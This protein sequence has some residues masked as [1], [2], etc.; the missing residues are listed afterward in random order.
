M[1]FIDVWSEPGRRTTF[2]IYL[3]RTLVSVSEKQPSHDPDENLKGT[4]TVLLVED[5]ESV[6]HLSKRILEQLGYVVLAAHRPLEALELARNHSGHID[7]LLTDVIMAGM[8][9]K[10]FTEKLGT[11]KA[12]FRS[13]FMSGYTDDVIAQHGV[14]DKGVHF[15]QK[16]FS[17]QNLAAKIREVLDAR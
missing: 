13:I 14:L 2:H 4:E 12:G 3:P 5:E 9:G 8:N 10:E 17:I 16:P 15:L 11:L 1:G 7:L 6:L